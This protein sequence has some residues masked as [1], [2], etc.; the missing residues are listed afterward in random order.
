MQYL[1]ASLFSPTKRT[2]LKAVENGNFIGWPNLTV[3]NVKQYLNETTHTAKGHLNQHRQNLQSTKTS[4]T[5]DNDHFS[6]ETKPLQMSVWL[7]S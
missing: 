5:I 7:Q 2:L 4:N 6:K 1:H 3:H